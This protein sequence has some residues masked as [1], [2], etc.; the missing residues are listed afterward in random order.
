MSTTGSELLAKKTFEQPDE[1]RRFQNGVVEVVNVGDHSVARATFQPGWRWSDDVK[2]LAQT[3]LCE[4]EHEL[5]FVSGR[6]RVRMAD[7]AEA[8]FGAGDVTHLAPN[9]DAWIVGDEPCVVIDWAGAT[10]Y[11]KK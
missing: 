6:M 8:E 11:A 1:V 9:H 3:P 4:V 2:P 10:T 7:G 5:Y